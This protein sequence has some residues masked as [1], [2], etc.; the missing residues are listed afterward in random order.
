MRSSR[1]V[2]RSL[3]PAVTFLPAVGEAFGLCGGVG[4]GFDGLFD[5][6]LFFLGFFGAGGEPV[7]DP[8]GRG[9]GCG[10][11][12]AEH[13]EEGEAVLAGE[14]AGGAGTFE[15]GFGEVDLGLV[16][17][18]S[19]ALAFAPEGAVI[20]AGGDPFAGGSEGL[21]GLCGGGVWGEGE[22]LFG[23]PHG[24]GSVSDGA[25]FAE[26]SVGRGRCR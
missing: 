14:F 8:L 11:G 22:N 6:L 2:L 4:G 1:K 13:E 18:G 19:G 5:F 15:G 24:G 3:A 20:F 25:C 12:G 21:C 7:G 23:R 26:D 17:F 16:G 9:V 10:G